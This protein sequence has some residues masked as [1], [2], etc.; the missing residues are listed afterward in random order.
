MLLSANRT[1]SVW[2][3]ISSY[4]PLEIAGVSS[5]IHIYQAPCSFG[6]LC[7]F[8]LMT[9]SILFSARQ[10]LICFVP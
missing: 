4:I 9:A 5:V 8:H 2:P 6:E 3:E 1:Y 7:A 10:P